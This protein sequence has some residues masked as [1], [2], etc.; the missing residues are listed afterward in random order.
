GIVTE[1]SDFAKRGEAPEK[2]FARHLAA[3]PELAR[4]MA[5]ARPLRDFVREANYSYTMKQAAGDGWL[6]IGDAAGFI[7][8]VFSSGLGVALESARRAGKAIVEAL[9]AGNVSAPAFAD[10]STAMHSGID[11]WREFILLYYRLPPL[12]LEYIGRPESRLQ[13]LRLLQGDV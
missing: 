9:K 8:P 5:H 1:K 13:M 4:R 12:F 11:I 10:Y 7:D 6:L 3:H 2:F